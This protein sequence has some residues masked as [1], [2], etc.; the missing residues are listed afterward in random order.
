VREDKLEKARE[1]KLV[2][3]QFRKVENRLEVDYATLR[4]ENKKFR[5]WQ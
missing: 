5:E 3:K 1:D 2:E 4:E